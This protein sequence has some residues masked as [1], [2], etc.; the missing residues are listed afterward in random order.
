MRVWFYLCR[1]HGY[2]SLSRAFREGELLCKW[3][4]HLI[5]TTFSNQSQV[6]YFSLVQKL[7]QSNR[8]FDMVIGQPA[9]TAFLN[10]CTHVFVVSLLS[11]HQFLV[12]FILLLLHFFFLISYVFIYWG[13]LGVLLVVFSWCF[14]SLIFNMI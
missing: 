13:L 14:S 5:W 4:E 9:K 1:G 12:F 11:S 7:K 8:H 6:F 3:K 10:K 2:H